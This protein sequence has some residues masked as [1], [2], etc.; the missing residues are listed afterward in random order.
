M[1]DALV[2]AGAAAKGAFTAGALAVLTE[3]AVKARLGIDIRRVV[4]ASSG[5]LCA[6]YL[7]AAI[8]AGDETHAGERLAELW[9]EHASAPEALDISF[10]DAFSERG[11]ATQSKLLGLLRAFIRPGPARRPI[12]LRLVVSNADGDT[13]QVAGAPATRFEHV[14]QFGTTEFE[15][16][17]GL[18][19]VFAAAVASAALPGLFAPATLRIGQGFGARSVQALDGGIVDNSPLTHALSADIT[20]V[21]VVVPFPR[22]QTQAPD[23]RGL[24]LLSQVFDMLVQE[25]LVRDLVELERMNRVLSELETRMPDAAQRDAVLHTL[26]WQ[27]RRPVRVIE[28]RP[29]AP[30]E[31]NALSGFWSPE[32]REEYVGAGARAARQV[33]T[34]LS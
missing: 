21:F 5:A 33:M 7:A 4:G 17:D 19:R 10:R 31:G 32:L 14:A 26:G 9:K 8:H 29:T 11:L 1:P 2:L 25:R 27:E 12:D 34:A 23:L 6:T 30:L 13:A 16:T 20:R 3:P 22:V 15:T 24:G 28:I 18:E